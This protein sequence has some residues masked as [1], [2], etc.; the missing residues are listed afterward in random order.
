MKRRI[1]NLVE[2]KTVFNNVQTMSRAVKHHF[3][4]IHL[5]FGENHSEILTSITFFY[6]FTSPSPHLQVKYL[7]CRHV[8]VNIISL[9]IHNMI[10]GD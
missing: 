5:M 9:L 1:K 6:Y 8:T 4:H 2:K 7:A 10:P 3:P